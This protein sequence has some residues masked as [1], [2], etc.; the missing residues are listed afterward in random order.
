MYGNPPFCFIIELLNADLSFPIASCPSV[1]PRCAD[2]GARAAYGRRAPCPSDWA[3]ATAWAWLAGLRQNPE[4][5]RGWSLRTDAD[6]VRQ[7]RQEM[8][9]KSK[10]TMIHQCGPERGRQKG[11]EGGKN[12]TLFLLPR[13]LSVSTSLTF[14]VMAYVS[15]SGD[16]ATISWM[17]RPEWPGT[18][19]EVLSWVSAPEGSSDKGFILDN[20]EAIGSPVRPLTDSSAELRGDSGAGLQLADVLG[21]PSVWTDRR[22]KERKKEIMQIRRRVTT[23]EQEIHRLPQLG[24]PSVGTR[25]ND[26]IPVK[27]KKQ[28]KGA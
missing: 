23:W 13:L 6:L 15:S 26:L 28:Q 19:S 11:K 2:P 27:Q 17:L 9:F 7:R 22:G 20:W 10:S 25:S 14:L 4:S 1:S 21:V 8:T 5:D 3:C 12:A 16:M 24:E 18:G